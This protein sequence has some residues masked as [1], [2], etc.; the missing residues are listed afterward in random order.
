MHG[1]GSI[2]NSFSLIYLN[3]CT[4]PKLLA[5]KHYFNDKFPNR[6]NIQTMSKC[7]L[8]YTLS[9]DNSKTFKVLSHMYYNIRALL[10][11][12]STRNTAINFIVKRDI[13]IVTENY[14]E[15]VRRILYVQCRIKVSTA[16]IQPS[17]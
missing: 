12:W 2:F 15:A 17:I 3:P 10:Y 11:V 16:L 4:V 13:Q 5:S 7:T 9:L 6:T 1:Y 14:P 8:P